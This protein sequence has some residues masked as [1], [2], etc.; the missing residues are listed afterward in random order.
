[1]AGEEDEDY[2]DPALKNFNRTAFITKDVVKETATGGLMGAVIGA[3]A[4]AAFVAI[5]AALAIAATGP[6][7][8]VASFLG[9]ASGVAAPLTGG[10]LLGAATT[11]AL[12]GGGI[13]ALV[14]GG[15]A[16]SNTEDRAAAEEERI[17]TKSQQMDMRRQ[18]MEAMEQRRDMQRVALERQTQMIR[19]SNPNQTLPVGRSGE[20]QLN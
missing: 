4:A 2:K 10:L 13:G 20:M 8:I 17:I 14:K 1:M 16:V 9:L 7:G 19:G 18:R 5:F 11:G 6:I 15:M 3:V 12:W